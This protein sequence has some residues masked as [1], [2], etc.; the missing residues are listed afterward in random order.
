M[1]RVLVHN[2]SISLDGF[3]TGDGISLDAPFGHAG[4]RLH[5]W[6]IATRFGSAIFGT[7][8]GT[9][10]LDDA[11]AQRHSLGIGAE[12]MGRGKFGVQTGPWPDL[13]TDDEWRGWWGPNPPFHTP[14]FVLTHHERPSIEMEGGTTFHS[15]DATPHDA[16]SQARDAAGGLDIRIGGGPTVVREFLAAGLI[17]AAHIVQ[18]PIV[19]GRNRLGMVEGCLRQVG[20]FATVQTRPAKRRRPARWILGRPSLLGVAWFGLGVTPSDGG[21]D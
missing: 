1:S 7:P 16:L 20:C 5:E 17:D 13:G 15:I 21:D 8:G 9:T 6:F 19:L 2:F 10:G 11:F 18:V 4:H 12:I 3:G 14:V